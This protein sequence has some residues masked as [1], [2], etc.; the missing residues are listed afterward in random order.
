MQT[1]NDGGLEMKTKADRLMSAKPTG[2]FN[3]R[4]NS[5]TIMPRA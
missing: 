4:K 2:T 1:L 5:R 3:S